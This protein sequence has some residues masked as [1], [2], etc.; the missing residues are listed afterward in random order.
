MLNYSRKTE[1]KLSLLREVVQKVKSG[2]DIDVRKALGT[3]DPEQEA[4]WEEAMK[5]LET[6]D[7]LEESMRKREAKLANKAEKKR[8][9]DEEKIKARDREGS[10]QSMASETSDTSTERR[11]KFMM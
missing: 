5:E 8:L 1:A 9:R 2:E 11:P 3:G 7:P 6:N 10:P 4:E